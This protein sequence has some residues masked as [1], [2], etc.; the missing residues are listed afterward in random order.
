MVTRRRPPPRVGSGGRNDPPADLDHCRAERSARITLSFHAAARTVATGPC[1]I[2]AL[3]LYAFC[4]PR[5]RRRWTRAMKGPAAVLFRW[6]D[7][8]DLA[9]AGR[10]RN[11]PADRAFAASTPDF[12]MPRGPARCAARRAGPGMRAGGKPC[13]LER[14]A[15]LFRAVASAVGAMMCGGDAARALD[16]RRC[17]WPRA[18]DPGLGDAKLT[19]IARDVGEEC[20]A[21]GLPAAR[22]VRRSGARSAGLSA[23]PAPTTGDPHH[24]GGAACG[25]GAPALTCAHEAGDRPAADPRPAPGSGR[26]G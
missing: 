15:R 26:R 4:R 14:A 8:L 7:R 3:A 20:P 23:G 9:Y 22:L 11:A 10:P 25:R 21:G 13:Q 2:R 17:P 1:A 12:D 19:N 16:E 6:N 18:C 5:R 24:G